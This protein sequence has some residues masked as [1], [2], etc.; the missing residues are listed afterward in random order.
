MQMTKEEIEKL[1][2]LHT[3]VVEKSLAQAVAV[4]HLNL[5]KHLFEKF[6]SGL[7]ADE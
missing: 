4:N 7:G 5:A 1:T 6:V 2:E 3:E